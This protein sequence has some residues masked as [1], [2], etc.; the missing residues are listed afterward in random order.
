MTD[1]SLPQTD[2][3]SV[4]ASARPTSLCVIANPSA[5]RGMG[6]RLLRKVLALLGKR[7]EYWVSKEPGHAEHLARQAVDAGFTT[8]IAAGG[9]GTVHEIANGLL[10]TAGNGVSL[11]VLPVGSGNDYAASLELP[12]DADRLADI[13]A[14]PAIRPVDVG[15][16][17]SEAGKRRWFVN[18]LGFCLSGA[19]VWE[20][21]RVRW[22]RG[23]PLYAWGALRAIVRHFRAPL[24]QLRFDETSLTTPTLFLTVAVGKREGG[25][26]VVAPDAE[27]DDG[28]FDYL[29]GS[30]IS[31][32]AAL[33]YMPALALGRLPRNDPAVKTGRCHSVEVKSEEPLIIHTDGEV[34]AAPAD[35]VR[36]VTAKVLPGTLMV[37]AP[38][39]RT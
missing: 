8:V 5:G 20:I 27:L 23:L 32:L 26:F 12:T 7:T 16:V 9:D 4:A 37:K 3:A 35:A 29:H 24:T 19:V 15:L 34:F 13:L 11:G 25:G 14:G 1:S 30:R 17:Q 36:H 6:G 38:V 28:W 22:L 39:L 10:E 33:W 18:T 21:R 31:R 2:T